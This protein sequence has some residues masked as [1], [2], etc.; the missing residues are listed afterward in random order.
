MQVAC[1]LLVRPRK[2]A[3]AFQDTRRDLDTVPK[4]LEI[5]DPHLNPRGVCD[6]TCGRDEADQVTGA[7]AGRLER[8]HDAQYPTSS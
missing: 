2:I 4:R 3:V 8:F 6:G 5:T 7:E 1:P